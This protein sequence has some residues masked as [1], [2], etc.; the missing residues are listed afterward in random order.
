MELRAALAVL[1]R[2]WWLLLT[3]AALAGTLA[4]AVG[5]ERSAVYEAQATLLVQQAPVVG[6]PTYSD[7]LAGQQLAQTYSQLVTTAPVLEEAATALGLSPNQV[8]T[9]VR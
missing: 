6:G 5:R 1:G 4:F 3:A 9:M 7:V 2:W 8:A